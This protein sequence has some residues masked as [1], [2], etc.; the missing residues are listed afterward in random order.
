[1]KGF[2]EVAYTGDYTGEPRPLCIAIRAI[3]SIR[4]SNDQAIITLTEMD[5]KGENVDITVT[6]SYKVILNKIEQAS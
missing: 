6:E 3:T 1:M 4:Q 5:K 2:I